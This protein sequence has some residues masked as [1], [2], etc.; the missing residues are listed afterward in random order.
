MNLR[1][2]VDNYYYTYGFIGLVAY[3]TYFGKNPYLWVIP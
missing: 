2:I 1:D 3:L